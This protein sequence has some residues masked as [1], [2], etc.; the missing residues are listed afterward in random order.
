MFKNVLFVLFLA[1]FCGQTW[2]QV[3]VEFRISAVS[4]DVGDMDPFAAGG[5]GGASDPRW[6]FQVTDVPFGATQASFQFNN[7]TN[8][9][10]TIGVA[11]TFF[12]Q[13][14]SCSAPTSFNFQWRGYER[15]AAGVGQADTG[16]QIINIPIGSLAFPQAAFTTIATYS[17]GVA[18]T[19]GC[20][21]GAGT[22]TWTI[23]L[24]YRTVGTLPPDQTLPTITCPADVSSTVDVG[25][26]TSSSVVLGIPVTADNCSVLSV[27]NNAPA[28]FPLG[29]TNV[30]WTVTDPTGN[31]ATC[32][33]QD[34]T[35]TD[36]E[37]P[38]ILCPANVIVSNDVGLCTASG[39]ALG[40][41]IE[42]DN[43]SVLSVTND[44]VA[45]YPIG[46]TVVT[47]TV[48]DG[49]LNT[50]SC[51]QTVTVNDTQ[52]PT[53]VCPAD[54]TQNSDAGVCGATVAYA[55][56][57]GADNCPGSI[58]TL[59]AGLASG[60]VFPSG[61]TTVTYLVTD[62]SSNTSTCSFDVTVDDVEAPVIVCPGNITQNNDAT[63]C[64]AIVVYAT[65]VGTDN[66]A[67]SITTLTG[68]LASGSLFPIGTTVVTYEV[69]DLTSNI[70]SCSF[71]VTVNDTENP[72]IVCPANITQSNDV[73][74][75][76]ATVAYVTPVGADNC[77]G[78]ITTLTAGQ[79]SG[80]LFPIGATTVTYLATDASTNTATCSFTITV[81]D[82]QNP[83][84][85]CP[86][87]ITQSNDAAVCGAT[88]TYATPVGAD[89]CPGSITTLTAGQ[90]SG[91]LFPI[92]ATT[93]TYLATDASTNT[94][95][96]S[97]TVTVNDTQNPT[98]VCPA[99]IT[100][101][102]DA[103][104]CGATVAY[105]TPVGADNCPG[106]ITTLT[107]GLASGSVFPS[108]V[109]TVTYLVTDASSNT[110]TCSFD[111]TVDDVEVP[112]I[113]CPGNITQNNDATVC[114]AIVV[115]A[116][117]VGTDNCAGSI[118]TLTGGLG[119]GSL[120]PI[121]TTVVTYEVEDLTSNITSCSFNVT[122][123]DTE[124]PTIV[125]PANITQSN[126]VG[127]C[128]A[129]VAYVTP[130]GADNCP[131]SITTLT[132]G[133][134]SGTLFPIGATTVTYLATDASTNTATCSFTIT[135]N[136]T[137]NPT[138]VC[139]ANITQSNDVGVCGATVTYATPVGA[140]N[141]PG[142]ITTLTAGQASGTLFPIGATTVTYLATDA[143]T[144]TATCSFTV[145]V[146]DTQNPTIVCPADIT[147]N[148]D[149]GVC[150][151]TVAYATPVGADNCP[152]SITTLTAGL[153]S[154]SV[155][156]SGVTTVT[157]LVTDASSNTSTCSFDVTVDDLEA[158]V[159][160]CPGNITQNNDATVCGA[161]VVYATPVGTDNCAGSIT[162]LTGGLGSGSLFPIGTTAVTYEVE[163]LTS[164]ITSCSFNVTVN[165]TELPTITCNAPI[166]MSNDAG[167]CGAVVTYTNTST[168]NCPGQVITQT[169]GLASGSV[170]PIGT[171]TNTFI[172]TDASGNTATCGFNV[173]VN[174]TE[175]PTIACPANINQSIDPGVC[176]ATVAYATPVGA[177]NCAGSIT[178]LTAGQASGTLFPTGTTTNTFVVT[179]ASGNTATCSFNVTVNDTELP[180][181]TCNAPITVSNDAGVCGA[182]VTY[183]NTSTDNCPGQ[184]ITQTAGLA[185]GSV[186]P[187][188]TTTNTFVVTDAS[189]NTATCS[190]NVTVNDTELPTITC[191]API[192]VSNDA[193]VCGAV[194]TYT[195]TSTDNCPGQVIT[196]TAG[197]ASGSVFPIGTTTNTFVV[198]DASGN[199]ATCSFNVTVND[200]ELPTITCNAPI[201]VS[202]DAGVC[203]AV[204]TY[205]NTSTDNCPGQVITQTAGLASGSVFPIGTTTNT[206]VVTD[207]SGN[208]ATCS[209][210]VTVNDTELPTITCNAPIT[211]SNDAGV[212]G[213]VVT[214]TN[215]SGVCGAVEQTTVLDK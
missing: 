209:F 47:W 213:A 112:V 98:I 3:T 61:V 7:N 51:A 55:T 178:T 70:T 2:S 188:G 23:T 207:A 14:Y 168:D 81:N 42:N 68:G 160:V 29:V 185:S 131:G 52:N 79:A 65:P 176:G 192:T 154:G 57:V 142:S 25:L 184:V 191:N 60:S 102:S 128:G 63:V 121:G 96:C 71:N 148:S 45:N 150:G 155:F 189:G 143:S 206:F 108:G 183:T 200:T 6:E 58:T 177:D 194:V 106:S 175:L 16:P 136:D 93:V 53:I 107:A 167:V 129:T 139:P 210:N 156:P 43:C 165:D 174:D 171:T 205:T 123:N 46:T 166:T 161:I 137:Q 5:N 124:N 38:A 125:C 74:V 157:Y 152:G 202:N 44:G 75:C 50:A 196:Q 85:V 18:G 110:S 145:T 95:T 8:C 77:P 103:G 33:S 208:T 134:A 69:E 203:G 215:T 214:Y 34:V 54:I 21:G 99:D 10:G 94:A 116:T 83:T 91:T 138:I 195:N 199:T 101:N 26:C 19:V 84:I 87:N 179:D 48:T 66:C 153:A 182:V 169:A 30:T 186:F 104:V 28:V 17:F 117:P 78:S 111:V 62:A 204:V 119:S 56:P 141:C 72:T 82:T 151:A 24:Q 36:I 15:D 193:G 114:G 149:A 67:G 146:N 4:S 37:N 212:C 86:A 118:T 122:V 59:T 22:V 187:I 132:A 1:L 162:T 180:T 31:S 35:V 90:A 105:A 88:V 73:G 198:T 92:G 12:S 201:T 109:T 126:D 49:S 9:P 40:V 133:Q 11:N 147:Q 115:Y 39:V 76:G 32:N 80:T 159:I 140:D 97:F 41:P 164:N 27:T 64:G 211:V 13:V 144:N 190:F 89:N 113:V 173:T 127:V 170:F 100:Q 135:V 181:I 120:F 172:V 130:V 163:D 197:L 20:P 158:P